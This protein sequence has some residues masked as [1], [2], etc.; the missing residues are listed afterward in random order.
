[1]YSVQYV[2]LGIHVQIKGHLQMQVQ[3]VMY[4]VQGAVKDEDLACETG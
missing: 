1:M 4:T 2:V 3:C